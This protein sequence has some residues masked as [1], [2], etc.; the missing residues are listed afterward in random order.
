MWGSDWILYLLALQ[1]LVS[2]A[3]VSVLEPLVAMQQGHQQMEG[4]LAEGSRLSHVS[5]NL[6]KMV[7][8][9]PV[10]QGMLSSSSTGVIAGD[11]LSTLHQVSG[12]EIDGV[13]AVE[14]KGVW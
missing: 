4:S 2:T 10:Q 3:R 7:A 12:K 11:V 9:A 13:P 8:T 1:A 6:S 5:P 14:P